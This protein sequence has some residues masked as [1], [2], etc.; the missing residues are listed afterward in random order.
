MPS[1]E[2]PVQ[3]ADA[4][5]TPGRPT[6]AADVRAEAAA[7]RMPVAATR[8][9]AA[10]IPGGAIPT[11]AGEMP[12]VTR[13]AIGRPARAAATRGVAESRMDQANPRLQ[14]RTQAPIPGTAAAAVVIRETSTASEITAR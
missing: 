3:A 8:T 7:I 11:L 4:R 14:G 13:A 9:P 6:R 2:V 1:V 5:R 10:E 12:G